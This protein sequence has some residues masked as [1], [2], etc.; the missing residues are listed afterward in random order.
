VR[1]ELL[2][3]PVTAVRWGDTTA[4]DRTTLVVARDDLA[5]HL[6]E[7]RRLADVDLQLVQPG[8]SCRIAPVF[9]IVEPRAKLAGGID[10]PGVLGPASGAGEGQT[11]VLRG[12]A[13]VVVDPGD[14][15]FP[16]GVLDTSG[17]AGALSQFATIHNVVVLPRLAPDLDRPEQFNALRH[18]SLRAAVYLARVAPPG[19]RNTASVPPPT[20]EVYEIPPLT[21]SALPRV[22]YV[23]QF[24]SHQ[25]PTHPG[26][27]VL[28]GDNVRQFLPTILHP[29]EILD[30]ALLRSY[31]GMGMETY[32]IQ[33]HPIIR[34]LYQRHGRELVFAGVVVT[35]AQNTAGE[36]ERAVTMAANLVAHTLR[37]DGAVLNKSGGGAPH[38]DMAQVGHRLE[39]MGVRTALLAWDLSGE[40]GG[41]AEGSALFNY[42]TLDA[43]VNYGSYGFT[44]AAPAVERV[45]A[46]DPARVTAL[47]G[48]LTLNANTI[49]GAMDQLGAGRLTAVT[50]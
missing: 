39:Q 38:V 46:G 12:A 21:D 30:G 35:V 3:H 1:L 11:A 44:V 47:A 48:P 22:A 45:L 9:D 20:R 17:P 27:P 8:E 15:P 6:L 49:C 26:E 37:A 41:G 36:R 28:Y 7:D 4:L 40:G 10:F 18:A 34:E 24:H 42:A 25:R 13:V 2:I 50:Y 5:R 32:S 33:N 14:V 16:A 43:I 19:T 29:N 23:F 31:R